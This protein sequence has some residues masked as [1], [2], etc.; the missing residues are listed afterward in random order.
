[1]VDRAGS[2]GRGAQTPSR[3]GVVGGPCCGGWGLFPALWGAT[4]GFIAGSVLEGLSGSKG[5]MGL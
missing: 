1:M 5:G 3:A 4:G 2:T